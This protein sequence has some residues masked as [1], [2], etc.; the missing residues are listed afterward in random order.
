[1][2]TNEEVITLGAM[3]R[4]GGS[5]CQRLGELYKVAD[6]HN[7]KKLKACFAAEFE[8]YGEAGEFYWLLKEEE[9]KLKNELINHPLSQ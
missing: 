5:F 6:P 4:F 7:R 1:M 9:R 3:R 2:L 8:R